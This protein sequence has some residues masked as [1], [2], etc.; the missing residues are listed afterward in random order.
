[1]LWALESLWVLSRLL[2]AEFQEIEE[3]EALDSERI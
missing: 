3:G 2:K 1:M